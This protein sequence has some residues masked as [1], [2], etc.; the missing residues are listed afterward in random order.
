MSCRFIERDLGAAA[1]LRTKGHRLIG[2]RPE[3]G[4]F[5]SFEFADEA[6]KCAEDARSYARGGQCVAQT[7]IINLHALKETLRQQKKESKQNE[8]C[9]PN[10][11]RCPG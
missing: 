8:S 4:H 3:H 6:G 5:L 9:H 2:L 7:L 10:H 11:S 1:Y